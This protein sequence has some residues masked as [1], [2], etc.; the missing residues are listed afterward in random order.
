M[1]IESVVHEEC[2]EPVGLDAADRRESSSRESSIPADVLERLLP[3]DE[4]VELEE[5]AVAG[6]LVYRFVKRTFDVAAC[7]LAL[8]ILAV[9]MAVIALKIKSESPGPV[10]YAQ[11][12][13]GKGGRTFKV[14]KFRTMYADA[15]VCGAQWATGDDPRVTPLAVSCAIVG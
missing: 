5:P 3:G 13:V 2:K 1:K 4:V 14:Y 9:P 6:G 10:I 7:G 11:E 15:E 8:A 12:R